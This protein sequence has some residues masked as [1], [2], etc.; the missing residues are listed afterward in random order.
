MSLAIR[1]G[2]TGEVVLNI[3]AVDVLP[4]GWEGMVQPA[5]HF[6]L[7]HLSNHL[8]S[9]NTQDF[10]PLHTIKQEPAQICCL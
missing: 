2:L 8:V 3:D 7:R 9:N 10:L 1:H 4:T 6:G 5:T